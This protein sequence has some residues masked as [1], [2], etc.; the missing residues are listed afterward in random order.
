MGWLSSAF[1]A[2]Y[3]SAIFHLFHQENRL[4]MKKK[5]KEKCPY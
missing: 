2:F 1:D 5:K 3:F 4:E